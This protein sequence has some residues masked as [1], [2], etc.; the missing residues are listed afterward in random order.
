MHALAHHQVR[1]GD[2]GRQHSYAHFTLLRLGGI[3]LDDPKLIGPAV[4]RD[5]D[6]RVSHRPRPPLPGSIL[7]GVT[8]K[9]GSGR[10][11]QCIALLLAALPG[12]DEPQRPARRKTFITSLIV[13]SAMFA[14]EPMIL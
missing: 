2:T 4:V 10:L 13:T 8:I 1:Q 9:L 11:G 7:C 6:A 3:S 14:A 12:D 5:D